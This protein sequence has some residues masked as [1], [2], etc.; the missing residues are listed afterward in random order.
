MLAGSRRLLSVLSPGEDTD[1]ENILDGV[2]DLISLG[3]IPR[4][5][6]SIGF[7]LHET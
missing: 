2:L 4:T 5:G 1:D 7:L 3:M 6:V